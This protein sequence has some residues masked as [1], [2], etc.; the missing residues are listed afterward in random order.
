MKP[1]LPA[2]EHQHFSRLD[3][4]FNGALRLPGA[5]RV[6]F[7][8]SACGQ[9]E[10][11]RSEVLQML[12]IDALEDTL[13]DRP[14]AGITQSSDS[15]DSFKDHEL[16]RVIGE[17]GMGTVWLAS[18]IS[19]IQRNVALKVL[20]PELVNRATVARFDLERQAIGSM[21]HRFIANV[22]GG[23]V[24]KNGLPFFTMELVDG[25]PITQF[26]DDGNLGVHERLRLFSKVCQAIQHAHQK[27]VIHR[28]LKPDNMV[29]YL[30]GVEPVVKVIDFGL[31]K[32]VTSP[33]PLERLEH[34]TQCGQLVGT[35]SYMSPE[36][37]TLDQKDIDTRSDVYSLGVVL[38]EL[39]T[40]STPLNAGAAD[41]RTLLELLESIRTEEPDLPSVRLGQV[42]GG[43]L[44]KIERNR[45]SRKGLVRQIRGDL[46][47]IVSKAI[48]KE[49]ANRYSSV[50]ELEGDV[51][52]FL[53]GDLI[54]AHPPT[55][56][57]RWRK[58]INKNKTEFAIIGTLLLT[59][60]LGLLGTG[61]FAIKSVKAEWAASDR[62]DELEDEVK[63]AVAAEKEV[64]L[65]LEQVK[66]SRQKAYE[67]ADRA[68]AILGIVSHSFESPNPRVN[69]R[70]ATDAKEVLKR[71]TAALEH[72]TLDQEGKLLLL[73]TLFDS[74][75][76]MGE[77]EDAMKVAQR[78]VEIASAYYGANHANTSILNN[79]IAIC[80]A[81]LGRFDESIELFEETSRQ[82]EKK[83]G[84]WHKQSLMTS[85]QYAMVLS[86]AGLS[87]KALLILERIESDFLQEFQWNSKEGMGFQ[88][89]LASLY[90]A[91]QKWNEAISISQELISVL[92]S[93]SGRQHP[94][95]LQAKHNLALFYLGQKDYSRAMRTMAPLVPA[96]E[97]RFGV[98]HPKTLDTIIALAS[99][100]QQSGDADM[101][102]NF[103]QR[104]L[105]NVADDAEKYPGPVCACL[106]QP[107]GT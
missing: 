19:P 54:L 104:V 101:A 22:L 38:Y 96:V 50:K 42:E 64:E 107:G 20:R 44:D 52:R 34:K 75:F 15:D 103:L 74:M 49:R 6:E 23:G 77:F 29:C 33:G 98:N 95:S 62:A 81:K 37:A 55:R 9:N 105:A 36:Q 99:I 67:A 83:V 69:S 60:S 90:G 93:K 73:S 5:E 1:D 71:A 48:S 51:N 27:G 100:L 86:Q 94:L 30:D 88:A 72:S 3:D 14:P 25:E 58:F 91:N 43:E 66:I 70:R 53:D 84:K 40:G 10:R 78:G 82:L 21:N 106:Q 79:N 39:L 47:W 85:H 63:R 97:R 12:D 26:C 87:E 65:R 18:Q 4:I 16:I 17:G 68:N 76:H 56:M 92:D 102:S 24:S 28:D 32:K 89:N 57:Y 2:I 8:N 13:L 11:L 45:S 80:L 46:D 41:E 7:V 31:A 59:L 35:V 61:W